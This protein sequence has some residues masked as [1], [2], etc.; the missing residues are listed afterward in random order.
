V[1]TGG[2]YRLAAGAR[3]ELLA[4][5][6]AGTVELRS[7]EDRMVATRTRLAVLATGRPPSRAVPR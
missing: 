5:I 3:S 6:A 4:A 2:L 7:A 1:N